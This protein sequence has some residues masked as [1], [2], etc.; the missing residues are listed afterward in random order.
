MYT[1]IIKNLRS[2]QS[3]SKRGL[4]NEAADALEALQQELNEEQQPDMEVSLSEQLRQM[5]IERDMLARTLKEV[6][7]ERDAVEIDM[8]KLVES[9]YYCKFCA[10]STNQSLCEANQFF[11]YKCCAINCVCKGCL[12]GSEFRWRGR[13]KGE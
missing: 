11:C 2:V 6:E 8:K 9:G 10:E 12:G 3:R 13:K 4:L 7:A 5:R 1:E